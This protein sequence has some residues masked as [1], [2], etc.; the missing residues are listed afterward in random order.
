LSPSIFLDFNLPNAATWF[1]FS[2]LLTVALFFQYY[3]PLALRNFDLLALFLFVPG[4]LFLQEKG[5]TENRL[6]GYVWLL[7]ASGFWFVRCL[8]D[9]VVTRRPVSSPNLNTPGLVWFCMAILICLT[10]VAYRRP[11]EPKDQAGKQPAVVAGMEKGA[12]AV[13]GQANV[14]EAPRDQVQFFASRSIAILCHVLIATG[15]FLIGWKHFADGPT[16]VAAATL[17][18]LLPYTAIQVDKVHHV[19]PAAL[20]V[21]A[22]LLFRRHSTAGWLAGI[23]AGSTFFPVLLLPVWI[24]FYRGRGLDRF[25][26][27]FGCATA[28]GVGLTVLALWATGDASGAVWQSAS[29]ADWQPWRTPKSESAW[30]GVHAA[31]RLPVFVVYVGFVLATLTWPPARDLGQ[32]VAV[33]AA[34]MIGVQFWFADR[35]GVYVLWYLPLLIVLV[36]RPNTT[37]LQ[38]RPPD[39]RRGLFG[40]VAAVVGRRTKVWERPEPK[41]VAV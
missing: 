4:F 3:R 24:Q 26:I 41:Q 11:A 27:A 36:L 8:V 13:I 12:A 23:A 9:T 31:Y 37:D 29:I 6:A 2:L 35:G 21:W 22:V 14:A 19:W 25:L 33:A 20:L 34:V 1:Y 38:P 15:L 10:A 39:P 18:L 40:R 28:V 30:T 17:Y 16:G 32:F 7:A 5:G